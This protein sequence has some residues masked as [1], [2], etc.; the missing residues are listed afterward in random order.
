MG[1]KNLFLKEDS[2]KEIV[3]EEAVEEVKEEVVASV[4]GTSSDAD[5]KKM[6]DR[7]SKSLA[8]KSSDD[9]NYLKFRNAVLKLT[10]QGTSEDSAIKAVFTTA[11]EMGLTKQKLLDGIKSATEAINAEKASFTEEL[12]SKKQKEIT[13]VSARI[14]EINIQIKALGDEKDTLES[15]LGKAKAKINNAEFSFS[16]AIA[17]VSEKIKSD[18]GKIST[19]LKEE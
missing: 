8:D 5:I 7:I 6:T 9:F 4:E 2:K 3:K 13:E 18:T 16:E 10:K 12:K 17:S 11:K 19:L 14:K 1:I 15:N